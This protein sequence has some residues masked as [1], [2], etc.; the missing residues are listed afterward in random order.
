VQSGPRTRRL[1]PGQSERL[2]LG[3]IS[4]SLPQLYCTLPAHKSAGM[5]LDIKVQD[6]AD[7]G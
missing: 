5:T 2:E 3:V 7:A 1:D 4:T 6:R